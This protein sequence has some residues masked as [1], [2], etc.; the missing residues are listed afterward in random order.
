[1]A[2]VKITLAIKSVAVNLRKNLIKG[3][4]K[5]KKSTKELLQSH[6]QL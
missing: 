2:L 6:L 4:I 3:V 1:M 5:M